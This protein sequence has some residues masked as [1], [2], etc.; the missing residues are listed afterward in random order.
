MVETGGRKLSKSGV[1]RPR[2]RGK[3]MVEVIRLKCPTCG[4]PLSMDMKECPSCMGPVVI[5]SFHSIQSF[6]PLKLNK[7]AA[8]YKSALREDPSN[9]ALNL[10]VAMFKLKLYSN[11][12][13]FFEKAIVD[14]FDNSEAYFYAA[15]CLLQGKKPFVTLRPTIDKILEYCNAAVMIEPRGIYYYFMAY[16]KYDYFARK[17]FRTSPSYTE[18]LQTARQAGVSHYDIGLLFDI[19]GVEQPDELK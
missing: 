5:T 2:E 15:V 11:A 16:V 6:P 1:F 7:Y 13:P 19:L 3:G 18:L 12:L 17:Y 4:Q 10:S 14:N 8:E 9:T